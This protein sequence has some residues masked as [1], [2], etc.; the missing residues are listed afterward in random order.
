M[1]YTFY[2]RDE[3]E[4]FKAFSDVKCNMH[5]VG[6]ALPQLRK[7]LQL[8]LKAISTRENI[9]I[10]EGAVV[11]NNGDR[12]QRGEIESLV[13]T[14]CAIKNGIIPKEIWNIPNLKS[15]ANNFLHEIRKAGNTSTH[16]SNEQAI[17]L[18]IYLVKN[19]ENNF[20]PWYTN[21]YRIPN[22]ESLLKTNSQS[23]ETVEVSIDIVGEKLISDTAT[24]TAQA[25]AS[26]I[27]PYI[28]S[29]PNTS[30][31]LSL[32][33]SYINS[34]FWKKYTIK[35]E[36]IV[37]ELKHFY[38]TPV[39]SHGN[40]I[41][42]VV[43]NDFYILPNDDL[44]IE[45]ESPE[46]KQYKTIDEVFSIFTDKYS[47]KCLIKVTGLGGSGKTTFLW[48]L[49]KQYYT[50]YKTFF[51]DSFDKDSISAIE[52]CVNK[53]EDTVLILLDSIYDA[54]KDSDLKG[55]FRQLYSFQKVFF[56]I[57]ERS[58]WLESIEHK[59][60]LYSS[61]S[62]EFEVPFTNGLN[63]EKVFEKLT[64]LLSKNNETSF[65]KSQ[66]ANQDNV[67]LV[68]QKYRFLKQLQVSFPELKLF[69]FDWED[70]EKFTSN[71]AKYSSFKHLY[72]F[73][74][75]FQHLGQKV[76]AKLNFNKI[77]DSQ[78]I[79]NTLLN[80][81]I[82]NFGEDKCPISYKSIENRAFVFTSDDMQGEILIKEELL[83]S[84]KTILDELL[85]KFFSSITDGESIY[86]FRNIH[87]VSSFQQSDLFG[88]YLTY[89][90]R[91][92]ILSTY[93]KNIP[94]EQYTT[95]EF[96]CLTELIKTYE[97][98]DEE[99]KM[100]ERILQLKKY[101][102]SSATK[103]KKDFGKHMLA[104]Y[105]IDFNKDDK[106]GEAVQLL[107]EMLSNTRNKALVYSSFIKLYPKF[108]QL[109]TLVSQEGK[110][111]LT[112]SE[113]IQLVSD[114][115]RIK[116]SK[117][118]T[119]L[120]EGNIDDAI[121]VYEN[122]ISDYP[123]DCYS[124]TKLS[125]ILRKQAKKLSFQAKNTLDN[126]KRTNLLTK[127]R[128][129]L[130]RAKKYMLEAL[131]LNP[132]NEHTYTELGE[133]FFALGGSS[134]VDQ[135]IQ[136]LKDGIDECRNSVGCKTTLGNI[137]RKISNRCLD[138]GDLGNAELYLKLSSEILMDI[139]EEH[140]PSSIVLSETYMKYF[141]LYK[142]YI[143]KPELLPSYKQEIEKYL[144][145]TFL[146]ENGE[147]IHGQEIENGI[148]LLLTFYQRNG[149][150]QD[151][152]TLSNE[153]L[154]ASEPYQGFW[155][156][157]LDVYKNDAQFIQKLFAN[158]ISTINDGK[159]IYKIVNKLTNPNYEIPDVSS[160][161]EETIK[162]IILPHIQHKNGVFLLTSYHYSLGDL[163][164]C[165]RILNNYVDRYSKSDALL[166]W[167]EFN[168]I[169]SE[170]Q[171][172]INLSIGQGTKYEERASYFN[173][174]KNIKGNISVDLSD[175]TKNFS[176]IG[177]EIGYYK[178]L[179]GWQ[180]GVTNLKSLNKLHKNTFGY[181]NFYI[182]LT[183]G[184]LYHRRR[185]VPFII[186]DEYRLKIVKN[187]YESAYLLA[188]E[189]EFSYIGTSSTFNGI[190]AIQNNN[191]NLRSFYLERLINNMV[192][193]YLHMH[194]INGESIYIGKAFK[195]IENRDFKKNT[196]FYNLLKSK[197]F[198][199]E[200]EYKMAYDACKNGLKFIN[201]KTPFNTELSIYKSWSNIKGHLLANLA[202]AL[203]KNLDEN[204]KPIEN[205]SISSIKMTYEEA[206]KLC[207]LNWVLYKIKEL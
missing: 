126:D 182:Y 185:E 13:G 116:M 34:S 77:F 25:V 102:E 205:E 48:H 175:K 15:S 127:R 203:H 140:K 91:V 171:F 9:P 65:D 96:K 153:V 79:S 195:I 85:A 199:R 18:L 136:Y 106:Y 187:N 113:N 57:S 24:K 54:S 43:A 117:A 68:I 72:L 62:Y 59:N 6:I 22:W 191:K 135:A 29:T 206:Y 163:T 129:S 16:T 95:N 177:E 21:K 143:P 169:I 145:P 120:I 196:P 56:A 151:Y 119:L 42:K 188:L 80:E 138:K 118:Q 86:L 170:N 31:T 81:A 108:P 92:Q 53:E 49:A 73:I 40:M 28:S 33:G 146:T 20:L 38:T 130:I 4:G 52:Q 90:K 19:Y 133:L 88:K 194:Y 55:F 67:S 93:L 193:L 137:Y 110:E 168:N 35:K 83:Q 162:N 204:K 148:R 3:E 190:K 30:I 2:N 174:A 37:E 14:L 99:E 131:A 87:R 200:Q 157:L 172:Y 51:L 144:R 66:T 201:Y 132:K 167:K 173:E 159:D 186:G 47:F 142:D 134:N 207:K 179:L 26:S 112:Q 69:S 39:F 36:N 123:N 46:K 60:N 41:E 189:N 139:K 98:V 1:S 84:Q 104:N 166:I 154:D 165:K 8:L 44:K 156:A 61:F 164:N 71:H 78:D 101:E 75:A 89:E 103:D 128:E 5:N 32:K 50:D 12:R 82:G 11:Y 161:L 17:A 141:E 45:Q 74:S 124:R 202:Y 115:V 184:E 105:Y 109:I 97:E 70:W 63:R 111:M 7:S 180:F 122:I 121:L 150:I 10:I 149:Y 158:I 27:I 76:P 197:L 198:T 160:F 114:E 178:K 58:S 152:N 181:G 192:D 176:D 125:S 107:N 23:N 183:I 94:Q 64:T 155:F 100:V 147:L